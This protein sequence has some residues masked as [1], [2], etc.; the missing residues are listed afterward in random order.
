VYFGV[1]VWLA[2]KVPAPNG[3]SHHVRSALARTLLE[4]MVVKR[5]DGIGT[6]ALPEAKEAQSATTTKRDHDLDASR[7]C[8][9][10]L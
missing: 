4:P 5:V 8:P 1:V 3:V 6:R 7:D 10:C 2:S 9:D